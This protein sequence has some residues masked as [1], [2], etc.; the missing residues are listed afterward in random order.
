[1]NQG[2]AAMLG[3]IACVSGAIPLFFVPMGISIEWAPNTL[4]KTLPW[5]AIMLAVMI[6]YRKYH[7]ISDS[8]D[9]EAK[10]NQYI[11]ANI[12][13]AV[14]QAMAAESDAEQRNPA[15]ASAAEQTG[16]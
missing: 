2:I 13:T 4:V 3:G 15:D 5:A 16:N 9:M 12:N 14:I 11:R 8:K 7:L 1:M 6:F 10:L